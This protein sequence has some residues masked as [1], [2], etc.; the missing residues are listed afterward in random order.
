[1]ANQFYTRRYSLVEAAPLIQKMRTHLARAATRL[2]NEEDSDTEIYCVT[3]DWTLSDRLMYNEYAR[4]LIAGGFLKESPTID[5]RFIFF[6]PQ[7]NGRTPTVSPSHVRL[8][9]LSHL[10]SLVPEDFF[11][12]I[13]VVQTSKPTPGTGTALIVNLSAAKIESLQS[14]AIAPFF[15]I[16]RT[17]YVINQ[18]YAD[19]KWTPKKA[20]NL[21]VN[22][23]PTNE[24]QLYAM[25][26]LTAIQNE[27]ILYFPI[28]AALELELNWMQINDSY[29]VPEREE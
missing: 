19:M 27:D 26:Y 16:L 17:N 4:F 23:E 2:I 13:R 12:L 22:L 6:T 14:G 7:A 15:T 8:P 29:C 25:Q 9:K 5:G 11:S 20:L 18:E 21:I 1:M 24:N 28:D 3:K 10:I